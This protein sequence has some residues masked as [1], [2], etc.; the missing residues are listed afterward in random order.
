MKSVAL[1]VIDVQE[2][3]LKVIP[4]GAELLSRCCFAVEAAQ[5][6]GIR[7]WFTT[8]VPEKLGDL[9][10]RLQDIADDPAVFPKTAFSALAADRLSETLQAAGTDH[11]LLAGLETSVCVYQTAV[12]A[13][14]QDYAVTLL[15]DCVGGRRHEDG[16]AALRALAHT[17]C[18]V[19]PSESVFYSIVGDAAHPRFREFT[20]LVRKYSAEPAAQ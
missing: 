6:L 20:K 16:D 10:P 4:R 18:H 19:L 7:V 13:T 17:G 2:A 11:L 12:A 9:H 8:Q 14:H 1:L 3:F 15:T 5:L